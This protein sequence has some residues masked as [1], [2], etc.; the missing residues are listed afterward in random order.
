MKSVEIALNFDGTANEV[1]Y[2]ENGF[3]KPLKL[4]SGS[5]SSAV[6]E[7]CGSAQD[8]KDEKNID[9]KLDYSS[10]SVVK[11]GRLSFELLHEAAFLYNIHNSSKSGYIK[12]RSVFIQG[13]YLIVSSTSLGDKSI[14]LLVDQINKYKILEFPYQC[15]L[16]INALRGQ[17][18]LRQL[19]VRFQYVMP[20]KGVAVGRSLVQELD[21][22]DPDLDILPYDI[23]KKPAVK[24]IL[25]LLNQKFY[26]QNLVVY[27]KE[28]SA[29]HIQ[30]QILSKL[31]SKLHGSHMKYLEYMT[32]LCHFDGIEESRFLIEEVFARREELSLH[33]KSYL[34]HFINSKLVHS[35][36]HWGNILVIKNSHGSPKFFFINNKGGHGHFLSELAKALFGFMH[37]G[38]LLR[39]YSIGD[40][41]NLDKKSVKLQNYLNNKSVI[42]F[43]DFLY[44]IHKEKY[45]PLLSYLNKTIGPHWMYQALVLARLQCLSDLGFAL[46]NSYTDFIDGLGDARPMLFKS[47]TLPRVV[48]QISAF[49]KMGELEAVAQKFLGKS[50]KS[51]VDKKGSSKLLLSE[52]LHTGN[53]RPILFSD[54]VLPHNKKSEKSTDLIPVS[55]PT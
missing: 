3:F 21:K 4:L 14:S 27:C 48:A 47:T 13:A 7:L 19:D 23:I 37:Q 1:R 28:L 55:F 8:L 33:I 31:D 18:N 20:Y 53:K 36:F 25:S 29:Y 43:N 22:F 24:L 52:E 42:F 5:G 12:S 26:T 6:L 35:D 40:D 54:R 10:C 39:L 49:D 9:T 46:S 30:K 50:R 45:K 11:R 17:L 2:S 41:L 44:S 51:T 32:H 38:N 16:L 15:D 34:G